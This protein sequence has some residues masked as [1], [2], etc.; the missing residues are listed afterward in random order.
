MS[1]QQ[2]NEGVAK[3]FLPSL[4]G[5]GQAIWNS[6]THP[7]KTAQT[8]GQLGEGVLSQ[9]AGALGVQ[10]D[11]AQKAQAEALAKA[12]ENHYATAYGSVKGFKKALATDPT[13]IMMDASTALGGAGLGAKVAGMGKVAGMLGTAS[14]LTDPVSLAVKAAQVPVKM[15]APIV[16][17]ASSMAAGVPGSALKLAAAAG[18]NSDPA[19]RAAYSRFV[20]GQ[21][22]ATEFAQAAQGAMKNIRDDASADY[23]KGRGAL[24]K[25]QPSFQPID[26]A[27]A[28]ARA[29][30][31]MGGVYVGQFKQ[32]N[33]ALDEA[34]SIID[35]W[36]TSPDPNYRTL[37]GV[38]NLK[39]AIWDVADS[40]PAGS[41]AN[42]QV[43]GVYHGIRNALVDADPEYAALMEKYQIGKKNIDDLTKTLGLGGKTAASSTLVKNLTALKTSNGQNLLQQLIGRDPTV[44]AMLAGSALHPWHRGGISLGE[45]VAG[46]LATHAFVPNP[47]GALAAGVGSLAA[48][49]PRIAGALN[50]GA[51]AAGRI[52]AQ[53]APGVRAA[54][55]AGQGEQ[56]ANPPGQAEPKAFSP[57]QTAQANPQAEATWN[58]MLQQE[59]GNQQ[60]KPDGTPIVSKKGAIGAAQ[61]MPGT[62]PLAAKLAGEPWDPNRLKYDEDYNRKLGHA[63]YMALVAQYG[64]VSKA[65]AAYNAGPGNVDRALNLAQVSGKTWLSHLPKE[66]QNYVPNVVRAGF[67]SG[68]KVE[69]RQEELIERLMKLAKDAKKQAE[70]ATEPLLKERD[71]AIATAL[72]IAQQ[73]L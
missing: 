51:G 28:K 27:L 15:A 67:A 1:W 38:D 60:F 58:N 8:I 63:L 62:G 4:A 31:R 32:A 11:P 16:R 72:D 50:Y 73:R 22:D 61:I 21:G 53:I 42:S 26:D 70:K 3:N 10:Q 55:Y 17:G 44:G 68:G 18:G 35:G 64:D 57:E 45:A 66:T 48:S 40:Y 5:T 65:A 71:E 30:T 43:M 59:S 47:V 36:K 6:V 29:K 23:L 54:Y 25:T 52:G 41:T 56:E 9:G 33:A 19:V 69:D 14:E 12:V 34:Q 13:G 37:D 46:G 24:A 49:S 39:Q 20:T 2:V 7:I